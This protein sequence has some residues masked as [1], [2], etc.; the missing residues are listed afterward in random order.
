MKMRSLSILTGITAVTL[1]VSLS[2]CGKRTGPDADSKTPVTVGV[3]LPLTG[4][5]AFLGEMCKNAMDLAVADVNRTGGINGRS[6]VLEY[7]DNKNDVKEG[8]A[9]FN[10]M[11][12]QQR[13][14]IISSMSGITAAI[15]PLLSD[16]KTLVFAG[17]VSTRGITEGTPWL[18]RLFVNADTDARTMAEYAVGTLH[19]KRV[20]ILAVNDEMGQAFSEVFAATLAKNGGTVVSREYFEKSTLDFRN[21]VQRLKTQPTDAFYLLGYDS[22]LGVLATQIREAGLRQP[23]LSIG[24]LAQENVRKSAGPSLDGAYYT[25]VAYTPDAA[26]ANT[27]AA[28]FVAAYTNHFGKPPTYFSAFSY[29]TVQLLA[30]A[31]RDKGTTPASVRDGLLAIGSYEGVIGSISFSGSQDAVFPMEVRVI[32]PEAGQK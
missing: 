6:L 32:A 10:R 19:L 11:K 4:N 20:T 25:S 24:T 15:K 13:E 27:R 16:E 18:F 17:M 30:V 9:L 14:I 7:A 8:L 22:N 21:I 29:D 5:T 12:M 3:L 1:L 2:G 23:L 26:S 28:A 31:M